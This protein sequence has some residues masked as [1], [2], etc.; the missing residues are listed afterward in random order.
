MLST[1]AAAHNPE[2]DP[3]G[4]VLFLA[5]G[6]CGMLVMA[7]HPHGRD[8]LEAGQDPRSPLA[9]VIV[10]LCEVWPDGASTVVTR[11][12]Q[13][14]THRE[15]DEH[16]A[17][18]VPGEPFTA[19]IRLDATGHAFAPGNRVRAG[20]FMRRAIPRPARRCLR[21]TAIPAGK[22]GARRRGFRVIQLTAISIATSVSIFLSNIFGLDPQPPLRAGSLV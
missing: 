22:S 15:S 3:G 2:R 11:A 18:L 12:L 20:Q 17:A 19:T 1:P 21:A 16:P 14:L 13:N 7:H 6:F 4:G 5:G 8:L 9:L 10:R